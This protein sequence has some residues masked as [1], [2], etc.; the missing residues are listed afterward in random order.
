MSL[1]S[2]KYTTKP[3]YDIENP[4]LPS[5]A[6]LLS[7]GEMKGDLRSVME[8]GFGGEA[9]YWGPIASDNLM[10]HQGFSDSGCG[11]QAR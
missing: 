3:V 10:L 2:S 4:A 1:A 5:H 8:L 7:L 9:H 6:I 11:Q